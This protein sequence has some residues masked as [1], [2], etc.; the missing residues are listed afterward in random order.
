GALINVAD[1]DQDGVRILPAPA[2]NL[3]DATRKATA[4][5]SPV[6]IRRRQMWP[7]KSVVCRIEMQT[8]SGSSAAAALASVGKAPSNPARPASFKKSRRVQDLYGGN[9][10]GPPCARL[11]LDQCPAQS[12]CAQ[13][14]TASQPSCLDFG[15]CPNRRSLIA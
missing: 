15:G 4:I 10:A 12:K 3:R 2:P 5:S 7:C 6:V 14:T 9:I 13:G 11:T 1:I 8:V